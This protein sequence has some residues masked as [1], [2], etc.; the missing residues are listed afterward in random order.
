MFSG[1]NIRNYYERL[2]KLVR[3]GG[4]IAIDNVLWDGKVAKP[5]DPQDDK[6]K[7]IYDLNE[8]IHADQRVEISMLPVSD[9][10]TLCWKK[11]SPSAP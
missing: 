2:L 10:V 1:L 3:P 8:F 7:A 11:P 9:G 5:I 6:T 4:L